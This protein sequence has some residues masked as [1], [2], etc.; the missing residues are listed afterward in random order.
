MRIGKKIYGVVVSLIIL[1]LA[2]VSIGFVTKN[3]VG[4]RMDDISVSIE[5][6]FENFFVDEDDVMALIMENEGDSIL[7]DHFGAVN[8]K[9]IEERIESHSF[10][11]EAEVFR[12]LKGHLVVTATQSKPVA[13]IVAKNGKHSYISEEG[14]LLPVSSKYTAR[15]IVLTGEYMSKLT[16]AESV[17]EDE[18]DTQLFELIEFVNQDRFW[19]MQIAEINV[20]KKGK[21][22]MMPQVGKQRLEFGRAEDIEDKFKRLKIFFKE[23]MPTKGWNTYARV[24]VEFK[25]Q[26]ICDK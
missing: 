1:V 9:E 8:L 26:I 25:D 7:G 18:Y 20:D 12:D 17:L 13:R 3:N 24:N 10:V 2:F 16:K 21:I 4:Y 14:L 15:V 22:V 5:N 23:I 19:K 6:R 11:K